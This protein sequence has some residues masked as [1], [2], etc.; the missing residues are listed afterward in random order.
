MNGVTQYSPKK[1]KVLN[2]NYDGGYTIVLD[3]LTDITYSATYDKKTMLLE[4]EELHDEE[5]T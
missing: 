2:I 4:L 5:T 1:F 3:I